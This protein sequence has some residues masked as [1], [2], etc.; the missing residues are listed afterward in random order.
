MASLARCDAATSVV[1]VRVEVLVEDEDDEEL[2]D[3][4]DEVEEVEVEDDVEVD[5]VDVSVRLGVGS[6]RLVALELLEEPPTFD[7]VFIP[8]IVLL[9]IQGRFGLL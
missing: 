5:L 7:I 4:V 9:V 2:E 8:A 3:E 6:G 1:E